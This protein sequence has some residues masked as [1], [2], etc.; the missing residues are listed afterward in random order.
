MVNDVTDHAA[1]AAHHQLRAANAPV[2]SLRRYHMPADPN[3]DHRPTPPAAP[4]YKDTL[5]HRVGRVVLYGLAF[6]L[7]FPFVYVA[8]VACLA[9]FACLIGALAYGVMSGAIIPFV[10]FPIY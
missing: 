2:P 6:V 7:L 9:L 3:Y 10:I 1:L 8:F 5:A 4:R